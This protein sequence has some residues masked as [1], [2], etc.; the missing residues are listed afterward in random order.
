LTS[1]LEI[2][3]TVEKL[4]REDPDRA[5]D[6]LTSHTEEQARLAWVTWRELFQILLSK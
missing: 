3:S 2:E 6:T 1:Q 4:L 5:K